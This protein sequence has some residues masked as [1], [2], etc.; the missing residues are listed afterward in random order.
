MVVSVT[1]EPPS[2]QIVKNRKPVSIICV[3]DNSGSM[4]TLAAVEASGVE[5]NG[6]TRLD[7]VKHSI[8][9]IIH[10][11]DNNDLLALVPFDDLASVAL[12]LTRMDKEGKEKAINALR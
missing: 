7:L 3:L 1:V 2:E 6:F 5:Q 8:N 10:S 4:G 11:L 12:E 9:T